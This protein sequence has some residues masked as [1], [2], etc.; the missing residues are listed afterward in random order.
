M[1]HLTGGP[2][3]RSIDMDSGVVDRGRGAG[4]GELLLG[5]TFQFCKMGKF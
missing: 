5:A 3:D 4:N 1:T 2:Y